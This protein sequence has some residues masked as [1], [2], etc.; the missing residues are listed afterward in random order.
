MNLADNMDRIRRIISIENH[1]QYNHYP[2]V[3]TSFANACESAIDACVAEDFDKVITLPN[4]KHVSARDVCD[5]LH[6][7]SYVDEDVNGGDDE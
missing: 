5:G 1:L 7:W 6:L 2:P 4:G 3:S